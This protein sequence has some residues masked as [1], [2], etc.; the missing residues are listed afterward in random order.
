MYKFFVESNQIVE[1]KI[2]IKGSDVNH[3]RN[4]LRLKKDDLVYVGDKET[5]V[6][7][8]CSIKDI[9]EENINCS[10][11][12][13]LEQTTEAKTYIHIFQGLPKL[14][15]MEYIIEK[16]TE[17]GV[18][19]IT[20]VIMDRTIVK[21]DEN[22]KDKKISRWT[23]IAEVAAKQSKRDE[24]LIVNSIINFK[25]MFENVKDYDILFL[26]YEEEHKNTLKSLLKSIKIKKDNLKIAVII[27]PEG[28][29]SE[30][31]VNRCIEN[32]FKSVSL[33]KRILRTETAPIVVA[34]NILYELEDN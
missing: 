1:D 13:R 7:Y 6:N 9:E 16:S 4:V 11:K 14:D 29:I 15:K 20:P 19:E 27:G 24:I 22:A 31:E 2:V 32:G 8:L 33:G 18:K 3:I 21:L 10:I 5:H 28:G 30:K 26:A 34:S 12:E 17:I 25:D 23:K